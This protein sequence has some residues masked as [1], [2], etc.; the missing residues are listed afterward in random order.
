MKTSTQTKVLEVKNLGKF[1][2]GETAIVTLNIDNVDKEV[3]EFYLE[4]VMEYFQIKDINEV[5][6]L[7]HFS[8]DASCN[9]P[10]DTYEFSVNIL[11]KS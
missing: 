8:N 4:E 6:S 7:K 1:H 10:I 9:M 3:L 5:F 11:F 2:H